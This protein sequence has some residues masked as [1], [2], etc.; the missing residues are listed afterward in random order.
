MF[1]LSVETAQKAGIPTEEIEKQVGEIV[2]MVPYHLT[3]RS[4]DSIFRE[5]KGVSAGGKPSRGTPGKGGR[6]SRGH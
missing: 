2:R 5:V 6:G 1:R 4:L 3:F